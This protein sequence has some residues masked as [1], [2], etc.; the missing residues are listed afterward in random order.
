MRLSE[1]IVWCSRPVKLFVE[2]RCC[3]AGISLGTAAAVLGATAAATG[4]GYTIANAGSSGSSIGGG[5]GSSMSPQEQAFFQQQ[6]LLG[7]QAAQQQAQASVEQ[8]NYSFEQ[9]N[10]SRTFFTYAAAIGGGLLLYAILRKE[11]L[12]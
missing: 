4:V 12:V 6:T 1:E 10:N 2:P 3:L 7:E 5:G 9:A 11:K 8:A